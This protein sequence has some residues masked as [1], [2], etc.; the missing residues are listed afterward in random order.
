MG[1]TI[2]TTTIQRLSRLGLLLLAVTTVMAMTASAAAATGANEKMPG[3]T[4]AQIADAVF[5]I[6]VNN[7]A[8]G[9]GERLY[10]YF[11]LDELKTEY[12][13]ETRDFDYTNHTVGTT[14]SAHGFTVTALIDS[15]VDP[16]GEP[17]A[18]DYTWSIQYLEED[19]YH[20]TGAAYIDT[21]AA[22][23]STTKPMLTFEIK[24]TFSTPTKY[25]VNDP[26]YTWAENLYPEYLR[27]YRQTDSANSAVLKMMMGIAVSP[28]GK[29]YNA[30]TAGMYKLTGTDSQ[31][32]QLVLDSKGNP[33]RTVLGALA[34]MK[35]GIP[36]PTVAGYVATQPYQIIK[37]VEPK[38]TSTQAIIF[39]YTESQYLAAK[40]WV[41]GTQ[42]DYTEHDIASSAAAAQIP[43][44]LEAVQA[45]IATGAAASVTE[46]GIDPVTAEFT[47]ALPP[48]ML[49]V[50]TRVTPNAFGYTD[51][52]LYRYTGDYAGSL[53]GLATA[54]LTNLVVT[55]EDGAKTL[56]TGEAAKAAFVAYKDSHSKACPAN[57]AES[58]RF[59]WV[60][61]HPRL[62][63]E[64]DGDV[65]VA[66]VARVDANAPLVKSVKVSTR[67]GK[68]T[69]MLKRGRSIKL[70]CAT[71]PRATVEQFTW[72]SSRSAVA[73][74]T[75]SGKVVASKSKTGTAVITVTSTFG[76]KATF[77][78]K[79]AR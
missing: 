63:D 30:A 4:S 64:Y 45:L 35:L 50:D 73:T 25:N 43:A 49:F 13:V 15:L 5:Y 68:R 2:L 17:L 20:A 28:D 67:A 48:R 55:A 14:T 10:Y 16:Y 34:G 47:F 31:G 11:T 32:N 54:D 8:D 62:I 6:A 29:T 70:V 57:T 52:N 51:L 37:S 77:K 46:E 61:D 9:T 27:V 44:G 71:S 22:A 33:G 66:S 41:T 19:A 53:A 40:N 7:G 69:A 78:V 38:T 58:K 65:L 12:G 39:S 42:T 56:L 59:T 18:V 74:V 21:I 1:G 79:V 72:K 75:A 36:A 76:K 23:R 24:E 60:Y 3:G 26:A